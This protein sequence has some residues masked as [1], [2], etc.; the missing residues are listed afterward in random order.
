MLSGGCDLS[1][2]SCLD[3]SYNQAF[4]RNDLNDLVLNTREFF[5]KTLDFDAKMEADKIN[6]VGNISTISIDY[7]GEEEDDDLVA[8]QIVEWRKDAEDALD[9][10]MKLSGNGQNAFICDYELAER[11][12]DAAYKTYRKM[13]RKYYISLRD[14]FDSS[15][16]NAIA[17]CRASLEQATNARDDK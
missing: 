12:R 14:L 2:N 7:G 17:A 3:C 5:K 8:S 6:G 9:G 16:N 15:T 13:I 1:V 11:V 10:I 4:V